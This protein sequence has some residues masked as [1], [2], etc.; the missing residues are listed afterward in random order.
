VDAT[1]RAAG[2]S[3]TPYR[4]ANPY[5]ATS[6]DAGFAAGPDRAKTGRPVA[7]DWGFILASKAPS[8]PPLGL[9]TDAPPLR[10]VS[11][12]VLRADGL[13]AERTRVPGLA[14]STLVHP[15]YTG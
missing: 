7:D 10:S 13:A 14:P 5:R 12:S 6:R 15:R 1:L 9:A 2:F 8:P 11:A 3:T 4:A